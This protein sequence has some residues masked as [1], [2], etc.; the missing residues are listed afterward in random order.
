MLHHF[1]KE[2]RKN[3]D[4]A[5]RIMMQSL[6]RQL[7]S[8]SHNASDSLDLSALKP[9]EIQLD[10]ILSTFVAVV[11]KLRT[12]VT[13]VCILDNLQEYCNTTTREPCKHDAQQI[14]TC[15]MTL[16]SSDPTVHCRFKM[17]LTTPSKAIAESFS[18]RCRDTGTA[19]AM[20]PIAR[21]ILDLQGLKAHFW[22]QH[23]LEWI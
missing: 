4:Q 19:N 15:L 13:I 21:N 17:L 8:R 5:A 10:S 3:G 18:Q 7:I 23:Q 6:L 16:A 1:C 2:N 20:H 12:D 9:S 22:S 11:K 14:L